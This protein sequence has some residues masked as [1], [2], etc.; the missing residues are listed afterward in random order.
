M[1]GRYLTDLADVCRAAGLEVHEVDGWQT[2]ARGSGGYSSGAPSHVMVHHSASP[3]HT[4]P[5][6]DI[7][8]IVHNADNAPL[9]NLY[10]SRSGAV[11]VCAAGATNTNGTGVDPCGH[12]ADDAMNTAAI[13]IEAANE[14]TGEAWPTVQTDAYLTLVAALCAAYSVPNGRIHGHA[15]YAPSRKIDPAGPPRWATGPATWAMDLFRADVAATGTTPPPVPSP[16]PTPPKG[17]AMLLYV[18]D[19]RTKGSALLVWHAD[20]TYHLTG[21]DTASERAAWIAAAVGVVTL[22]DDEYTKWV[23]GSQAPT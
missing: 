2:R 4:D 10:L 14:G 19:S 7:A 11:H 16:T 17:P 3:P 8:Y 12:V 23:A 9:S 13:G 21:F 6:G 15:E 1:A 18:I 20:G 5:D 22:E